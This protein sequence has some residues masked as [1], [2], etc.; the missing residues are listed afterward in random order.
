LTRDTNGITFKIGMPDE[1]RE[2]DVSSNECIFMHGLIAF[3]PKGMASIMT[4]LKEKIMQKKK[5]YSSV[6]DLYSYDK[7]QII[8]FCSYFFSNIYNIK[9]SYL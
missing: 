6:Y 3:Q 9:G 7:A 2:G 1:V 8:T 4:H 5:V